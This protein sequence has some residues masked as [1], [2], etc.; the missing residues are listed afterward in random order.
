MSKVTVKTIEERCPYCHGFIQLPELWIG[1]VPPKMCVCPMSKKDKKPANEMHEWSQTKSIL[2]GFIL[3][4]I[5]IGLFAL[6]TY[7]VTQ[8]K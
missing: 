1:T 3:A 8:K 2:I 7:F 6:I 4:S 5:L